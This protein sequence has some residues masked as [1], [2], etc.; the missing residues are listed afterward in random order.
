MSNIYI[1]T[2]V[3][4]PVIIQAH[5][6]HG[7]SIN[8]LRSAL[9]KKSALF[10]SLH[11]QSELYRHLTRNVAPFTMS[12][13]NVEDVLLNDFAKLLT[14]VAGDSGVY[15]RSVQRLS[16]QGLR[17][18]IIYDALHLESAL[19]IKAS[20]LYTDNAKDFRRLLTPD[21]PIRIEGIR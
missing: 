21:D 20:I 13:A 4:L 9:D 6:N 3:L 5:E 16:G 8:V 19:A 7:R 18:A 10:T 12:P 1:D 15:R 11:T 14:Y 2:S 17:G